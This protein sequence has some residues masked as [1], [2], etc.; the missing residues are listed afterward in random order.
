M[1]RRQFT[2]LLCAGAPALAFKPIIGI[3]TPRPQVAITMDDF[4]LFG[5]TDSEK[6]AN[7][8]GDPLGASR[9]LES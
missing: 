8:R 9:A 2:K 5:E 7:S 1:R 6:E 4:N 3:E